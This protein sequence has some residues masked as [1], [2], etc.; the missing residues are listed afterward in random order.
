MLTDSNDGAI[1][2]LLVLISSVDSDGTEENESKNCEEHERH[3][4][5]EVSALPPRWATSR[6]GDHGEGRGRSTLD[7]LAVWGFISDAGPV[8]GTWHN[9]FKEQI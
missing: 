8:A 7:V 4:A 5:E 6:T 1:L 3:G 9:V 2:R